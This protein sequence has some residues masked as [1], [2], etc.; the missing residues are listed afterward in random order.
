MKY[1][2]QIKNFKN[3]T[4]KTNSFQEL[5]N[6]LTMFVPLNEIISIKNIQK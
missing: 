3:K 6:E 2:V 4:Y 5:I 1:L